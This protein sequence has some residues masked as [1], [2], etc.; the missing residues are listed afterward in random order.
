MDYP[1]VR[2]EQISIQE[3]IGMLETCEPLLQKINEQHRA[4]LGI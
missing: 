3:F 1:D 2:V 4:G